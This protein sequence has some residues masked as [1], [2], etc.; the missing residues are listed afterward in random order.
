VGRKERGHV[1]NRSE[2]GKTT[3][4]KVFILQTEKIREGESGLKESS[5]TIPRRERKKKNNVGSENR[6]IN[7]CPYHYT[8][9]AHGGRTDLLGKK[10]QDCISKG[11]GYK[12][13]EK[14]ETSRTKKMRFLYDQRVHWEGK[15]WKSNGLRMSKGEGEEQGRLKNTPD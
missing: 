6:E 11:S 3:T 12:V 13:Q 4:I 5:R 10:S 8:I 1:L 2:T 15:T 9:R 7:P 14:K